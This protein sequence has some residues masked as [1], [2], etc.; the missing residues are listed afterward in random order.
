[1]SFIGSSRGGYAEKGAALL[2][3]S[4]QSFSQQ[5]RVIKQNDPGKTA[6][7]ALQGGLAG[8]G[9]GAMIGSVVPGIGTAVGAV[10]GAIVGMA[11]Y[12]LS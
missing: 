8:A 5:D 6:G 2:G 10:G 1:M 11:G 9:T 4:A 3:Q 7:G 12:M